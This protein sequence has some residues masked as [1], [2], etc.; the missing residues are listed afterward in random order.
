MTCMR[1]VLL[2]GLVSGISAITFI[3][4]NLGFFDKFP[5][6]PGPVEETPP[7]AGHDAQSESPI[8]VFYGEAEQAELLR[9]CARVAGEKISEHVSEL[10]YDKKR[11]RHDEMVQDQTA[12]TWKYLINVHNPEVDSVV[13]KGLLEWLFSPPHTYA[14]VTEVHTLCTAKVG[15]QPLLSCDAGKVAVEVGSSIGM[16]SLYL[17]A[18]GMRV[19]AIDPVLPNTQRLRTR[20]HSLPLFLS[21]FRPSLP[22]SFPLPSPSPPPPFPLR[23]PFLPPPFPLCP[24]QLCPSS[25]RPF[26]VVSL[27]RTD[28]IGSYAL[29][30][31]CPVVLRTC[32]AR[33]LTQAVP[34]SASTVYGYHLSPPALT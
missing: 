6:S 7:D 33:A 23:S 1:G 34:V 4:F 20:S 30:P 32:D 16:V 12:D 3:Y 17:A 15:G 24:P 9:I 22:A 8:I 11:W 21:P 13:S 25:L 2:A 14:S 28:R 19:F 18:R 27:P 10:I 31:R 26:G 29:A 5:E